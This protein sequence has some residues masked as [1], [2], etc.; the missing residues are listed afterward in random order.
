M[1]RKPKSSIV[2]DAAR[3]MNAARVHPRGGRQDEEGSG[4]EMTNE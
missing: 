1:K 4:R 3:A 2:S